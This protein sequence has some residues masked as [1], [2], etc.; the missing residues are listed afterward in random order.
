M[1]R[2]LLMRKKLVK[3]TTEE[4]FELKWLVGTL[5]G[6]LALWALS[7][8]DMQGELYA[9]IGAAAI[10]VALFKPA[11]TARIPTSVW[12]P[13]GF[14]LI[15]IVGA[16][17]ILNLPE[18]MPPLLRM[19]ILLLLYKT[20]APRQRRDD[21][22]IVLLCLFCLVI[23]GV[24]TVSLLFA[25]QILL[26]TPVAM[27]MLFLI[28]VLDRGPES[29]KHQTD[30]ESF[31]LF[32]LVRRL[33]RV[34]DYR[35][36]FLGVVMFVFVVAVST[37]L[38]ILTPRVDIHQ[39]I[40]YL[41]IKSEARA[42]FSQ[43]VKLGEVADIQS[44]NEVALR[45][46][47]P[48][49]EAIEGTPY[50]RILTLDKYDQ[51]YFRMSDTLQQRPMRSYLKTRE[52]MGRD[53]LEEG[54]E[55]G[56][57]S[58]ERWTLYLEGGTSQF[59]PVPGLFHSMRFEGV[60]DLV[61][62]SGLHHV[63]LLSVQQRVFSYQ[64]EDLRWT[65]RF[66]AMGVEVDAFSSVTTTLEGDYL[67]YPMTTLE[68]DLGEADRSYLTDLNA[69][70]LGSSLPADVSE[71]SHLLTSHLWKHFRYSLSPD[72][73]GEGDDA[74]VN[75]LRSAKAG[76]CEYFAGSFILLAR[77]AGYPARMVVGF[78]GGG[79]NTVEEYFVVRNDN[80]HAWVEIYDSES[81]EWLRVDPTPGS[82]SANPD[83]IISSV[84]SIE[85]GWG[86]WIDSLRIQ[87]YRRVVNF[88]QGDQ[89]DMAI[90]I[91]DVWDDIADKFSKKASALGGRFSE[92]WRNPF[93]GGGMLR[94]VIV[95]SILIA[96]WG[97]WHARYYCIGS[98]YRLLRNT[99]VLDPLRVEASRWL[100]KLKRKGLD[101]PTRAE[102]EAVR[103]G[104]P[105]T[106]SDA[107]SVFKR[108]RKTIKSVRK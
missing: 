58:A 45:V 6:L 53:L 81:E 44:N 26:F 72:L 100:R 106:R 30:W 35:V 57:Q 66:P 60:Q 28:C 3:L 63:G 31:T 27:G 79:W 4:L 80:A 11:L 39:A 87:W 2:F 42:G 47:V 97:L 86:A 10:I 7:S 99:K 105:T 29:R 17:F 75:W 32:R 107:K 46:D 1:S 49:L 95:V 92:W 13:L 90:T 85:A 54:E 52:L 101:G 19:V 24:M 98:L 82:G 70:I 41:Q 61:I 55:I 16:D 23:S 77:E 56:R 40:P 22:Q 43:N 12:R 78:T 89:L 36:L 37:V 102:L 64:I 88:D 48:S 94:I 84:Q 76:H 83:V 25:V 73:G 93:S 14:A 69:K 15:L 38:F 62:N 9:L 71:Y 91:K 8:L 67:E 34:L 20:F 74:I 103:F 65:H 59:L 5:L 108:A 18:F 33:L 96:A 68:L 51:G 21:L 104:P 50:W